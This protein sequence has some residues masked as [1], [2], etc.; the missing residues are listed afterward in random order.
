MPNKIK[1][2][3]TNKNAQTNRNQQLNKLG[4]NTFTTTKQQN[5]AL[6]AGNNTNTNKKTW[7]EKWEDGTVKKYLETGADIFKELT[8]E[9]DPVGT[10]SA[11]NIGKGATPTDTGGT[12]DYN[13]SPVKTAPTKQYTAMRQKDEDFLNV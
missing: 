5:N 10:G 3:N 6:L 8:P 13:Y 4:A 7:K 11:G 9:G 1:N 12:G 2:K